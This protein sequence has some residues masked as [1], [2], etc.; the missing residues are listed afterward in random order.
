MAIMVCGG[1][2]YIGSH[3]VAEL[4]SKREDVIVVDNLQTGHQEALLEGAD[5]YHGDLRDQNFI[6]EVF[7]QNSVEAVIHF[8]ADSLV[9]ESVQDPLKYFDN[10]VNGTISLLKA[11]NK[12]DVKNIVFSSTAAAY[13]EPKQIP[14]PEESLTNPTNP[15]GESKLAVEKLLYWAEQAYGLRYTIFRYFN[16]AGADLKGRLGEDHEPETHLIPIILQVALGKRDHIDIYGDDYDTHDGT[17]VRDYIHVKD[18]V[19]AHLLAVESLEKHKQSRIYNLGNGSGFSVKEI[20][21]SA[22]RVTGKS[23][24]ARIAPRRAGDPANLVASP[25]K[26]IEELGW[27]PSHSSID[28]MI[29]SAWKWFQDHPNG[30]TNLA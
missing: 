24:P 27:N 3:A 16:V 5:F 22:R 12:Y 25:A 2:G 30:Y 26:A 21:E 23:I 1:A 4:L 15:Y 6:N 17:C 28:E 9:G 29:E 14:I 10:N 18:L 7:E 11:M 19:D 8:A 13:G 20:I